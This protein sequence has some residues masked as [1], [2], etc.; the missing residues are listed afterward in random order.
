M[1]IKKILPLITFALVL[2]ACGEDK[3]TKATKAILEQAQLEYTNKH[4]DK[5]LHL[6]DSLRKTYPQAIEARK[7]ALKLF[8]DVSLTQAQEDLERTDQQIQKV[9]AEY[10]RMKAEAD[11]AKRALQATTTQLQAVTLK[12][13]ELDSL[14]VRFDMQCAKIK[15]I[16]KKQKEQ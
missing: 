2:A 3:A 15:Y 16:H 5:A 8:Q 12:K 4:Y 1:D 6:I 11:R 7:T 10:N 14:Q 13:I 9:K